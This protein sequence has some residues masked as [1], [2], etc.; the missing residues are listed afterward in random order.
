MDI[1]FEEI[2]LLWEN[3]KAHAFPSSFLT[4]ALGFSPERMEL[5]PRFLMYWI[6]I[7]LLCG[8]VTVFLRFKRGQRSINSLAKQLVNI[9]LTSCCVLILPIRS[10]I[11]YLFALQ[12]EDVT[13]PDWAEPP[14]DGESALQDRLDFVSKEYFTKN[15]TQTLEQEFAI[16]SGE[17][18][19]IIRWEDDAPSLVTVVLSGKAVWKDPYAIEAFVESLLACECQSAIE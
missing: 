16:T 14:A 15:L 4:R 18:R 3:V 7:Y 2:P 12:N 13:L 10:G 9:I 17:V 5:L 8:L 6:G 19:C 1:L 11:A